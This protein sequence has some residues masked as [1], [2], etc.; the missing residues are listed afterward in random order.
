MHEMVKQVSSEKV[1]KE[2]KI[3]V[4]SKLREKAIIAI[5]I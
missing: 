5:L 4:T 1:E 3:E 2:F